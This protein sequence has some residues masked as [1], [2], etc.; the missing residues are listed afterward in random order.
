M[1][2]DQI[3]TGTQHLRAEREAGVL[4]LTLNGAVIFGRPLRCKGKVGLS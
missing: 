3:D 2:V 1:K 4:V